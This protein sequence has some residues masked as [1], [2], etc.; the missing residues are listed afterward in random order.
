MTHWDTRPVPP[1]VDE[2][3]AESLD[4]ALRRT[5]LTFRGAELVASP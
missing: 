4:Q 1:P 5:G 2:P 3:A